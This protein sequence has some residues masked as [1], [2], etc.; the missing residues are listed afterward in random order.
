MARNTVPTCDIATLSGFKRKR[1]TGKVLAG[2]QNRSSAASSSNARSP[3]VSQKSHCPKCLELFSRGE[4]E[5]TR[6]EAKAKDTKKIRGQG[7]PFRGQTPSRPRTGMLEAKARD[8]EHSHKCSPKKS[9][10]KS[11]SDDLQFKGVPRI[12]D[13]GRI[14]PQITCNDF[15]KVFERGSFCGTKIS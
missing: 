2:G 8:Q 9:V 5:N 7:Q 1:A 6:L 15:T 14:K 10:Q 13:W 4:V 11:F 3:N 12:F